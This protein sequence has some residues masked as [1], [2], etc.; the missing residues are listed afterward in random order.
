MKESLD[1]ISAIPLFDGL[2][3]EQRKALAEIIVSKRFN[4]GEIIFSEGEEA[5]GFY[6]VAKGLVKIFKL[7][8]EG[9]TGI[10]KGVTDVRYQQSYQCHDG[11]DQ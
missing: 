2:P 8:V 5:D 6:V 10:D 9:D 4:K 3:R 1:I 11:G 7:S